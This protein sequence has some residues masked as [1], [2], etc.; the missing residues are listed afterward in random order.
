MDSGWTLGNLIEGQAL[1]DAS[2]IS[3]LGKATHPSVKF[4]APQS[5]EVENGR[6]RRRSACQYWPY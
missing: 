2:L 4:P 3:L 6:L 1:D 5:G